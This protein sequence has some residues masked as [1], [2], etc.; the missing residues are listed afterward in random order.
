MIVV[1]G[2][3]IGGNRLGRKLGFPTANIKLDKDKI[4]LK[5]GVYAG[6]TKVD[7]KE[8]ISIINCGNRPTFSVD[9]RV[10][11][12][13]LIDFDGYLYNKQIEIKFYSFLRDIKKFE[14]V[15]KLKE[16]LSF[17]IVKAKEEKYD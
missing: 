5:D 4:A 6:K 7:E 12:S 17:D 16:Q 2:V 1:E 14:N 11:E 3:V 8:Y 13:H 10:I 15:E 9:E